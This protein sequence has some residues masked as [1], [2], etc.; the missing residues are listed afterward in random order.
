LTELTLVIGTRTRCADGLEGEV[1]A[2]VVDAAAGKVTHLAV[3]PKGRAGLARLVSL[4]LVEAVNGEVLLRCTEAQFKDLEAAEETLAPYLPSDGGPVQVLVPGWR[5][6]EDSSAVEGATI[7][8]IPEQ[9]TIDL[10]PAGEVEEHRGDHVVATDGNAGQ[11]RAFRI[12]A[13]SGQVTAVLVTVRHRPAHK[14]VAI[15][16]AHVT[17]FDHGIQV[18]LTTQQVRDLPPA[19]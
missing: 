10:V 8:S 13:A 4:D 15:P 17:G 11:V 1:R 5:A 18:D 3:E 12:D 9:D 2:L 16:F 7:P 14:P 19:E 6:A